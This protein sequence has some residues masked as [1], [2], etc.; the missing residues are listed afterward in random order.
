MKHNPITCFYRYDIKGC[1]VG[2][3]TDPTPKKEQ[4]IVILKDM[5]FEGQ[6]IALGRRTFIFEMI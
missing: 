3:W 1:E 6:H 4:A 5:N 2:R